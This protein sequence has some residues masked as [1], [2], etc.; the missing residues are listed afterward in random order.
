MDSKITINIVEP[1]GP[2][3]DPVVPNTGLFTHGIG[4][5]EATIITVVSTVLLLT[6]VA[7]V[8]ML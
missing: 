4:G 5:P 6:I 1:G 7:V 3:P 2:T 8:A